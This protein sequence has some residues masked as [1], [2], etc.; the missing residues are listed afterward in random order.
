MQHSATKVIKG[1]S[2]EMLSTVQLWLFWDHRGVTC[3][4]KWQ[5]NVMSTY[6]LYVY[7]K[8]VK[9]WKLI[10]KKWSVVKFLQ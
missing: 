8:T 9:P 5:N 1:Y 2:L 3:S 7:K 4:C 10:A 6:K